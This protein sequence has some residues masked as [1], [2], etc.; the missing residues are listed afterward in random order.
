MNGF[1]SLMQNPRMDGDNDLL[2]ILNVA[3]PRSTISYNFSAS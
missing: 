2:L 3:M 1:V